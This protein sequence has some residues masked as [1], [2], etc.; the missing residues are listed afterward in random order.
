MD[1][2]I[3][4]AVVFGLVLV[5]FGG[6]YFALGPHSTELPLPPA[7]TATPA[8]PSGTAV[9]PVVVPAPPPP[10]MATPESIEAEIAQSE[11]AELLALVKQNF[12]AE[13]TDLIAMAVRNR[14]EGV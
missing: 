3:L 13:Y 8:A 14:N 10:P 5:A 12:N 4:I 2:R 11:H 9:P 1:L 7:Q 6:F